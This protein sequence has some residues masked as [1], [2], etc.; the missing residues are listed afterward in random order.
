MVSRIN[1]SRSRADNLTGRFNSEGTTTIL[2]RQAKDLPDNTF[3]ATGT[4]AKQRHATRAVQ[5]PAATGQSRTWT[6]RGVRAPRTLSIADLRERFPQEVSG[7]GGVFAAR[8]LAGPV[9]RD[10][11][12]YQV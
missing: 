10:V 3:S 1:S 11:E 4:T 12:E 7:G 5:H 2:V 8:G 6:H 9:R